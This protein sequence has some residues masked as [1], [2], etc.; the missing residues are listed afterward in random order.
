MESWKQYLN[1]LDSRSKYNLHGYIEISYLI[2]LCD[3][4]KRG[5]NIKQET[6][7]ADRIESMNM[8]NDKKLIHIEKSY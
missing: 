2:R 6:L 4:L 5:R 3:K 7:L 1:S 8:I